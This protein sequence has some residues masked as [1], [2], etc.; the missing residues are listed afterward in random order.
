[1]SNLM[2]AI[3]IVLG[4]ATVIGAARLARGSGAWRMIAMLAGVAVFVWGL[5][6]TNATLGSGTP[7]IAATVISSVALGA[8]IGFWVGHASGSRL[9]S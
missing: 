1:M 6:T 4:V 3:L 2:S 5:F 8:L 7:A 9:H